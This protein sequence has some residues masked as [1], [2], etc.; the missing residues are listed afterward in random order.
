MALCLGEI[1]YWLTTQ[2]PGYTVEELTGLETG[3]W[4]GRY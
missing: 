1:N 2:M 3:V 4:P